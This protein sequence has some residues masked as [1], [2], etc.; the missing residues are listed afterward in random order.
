M[1][2]YSYVYFIIYRNKYM[3]IVAI[4]MHFIDYIIKKLLV[5]FKFYTDSNYAFN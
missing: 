4:W 1:N 2:L 5:R 3:F